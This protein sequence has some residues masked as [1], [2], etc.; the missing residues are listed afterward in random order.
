MITSAYRLTSRTFTQI[1]RWLGI[2]LDENQIRLEDV[3][4]YQ[5]QSAKIEKKIT[6]VDRYNDKFLQIKVIWG[7]TIK[8]MK[9]NLF[10]RLSA[11]I[12]WNSILQIVLK[13]AIVSN[14]MARDI[15]MHRNPFWLVGNKLARNRLQSRA[16]CYTYGVRLHL[17]CKTGQH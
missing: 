16:R 13:I 9:S 7:F 3:V 11:G 6:H 1:G 10:K 2:S 14:N 12:I 8:Q 15:D 17:R 4:I 5:P